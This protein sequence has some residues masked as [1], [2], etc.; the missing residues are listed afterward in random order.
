MNQLKI[1]FLRYLA[2]EKRAEAAATECQ[3]ADGVADILSVERDRVHE[4]ELKASLSDAIHGE[5]AKVQKH[6]LYREYDRR[7]TWIPNYFTI[8]IPAE[9]LDDFLPRWEADFDE[10]YGIMTYTIV[11]GRHKFNYHRRPKR[12]HDGRATK[13]KREIL[14]RMLCDNVA[15]LESAEPLTD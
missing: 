2:L 9:I 4:V 1:D 10:R 11:D 14:R 7:K 15:L 6:A 3:V 5:N 12:L 13:L 8:A